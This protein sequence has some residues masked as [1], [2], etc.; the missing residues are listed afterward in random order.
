M[1][2]RENFVRKFFMNKQ[3][4]FSIQKN[5]CDDTFDCIEKHN[6]M[7]LLKDFDT[8]LSKIQRVNSNRKTTWKVKNSTKKTPSYLFEVEVKK[9]N[10][11]K[12][13]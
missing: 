1:R 2:Q 13:S 3:F 12:Q 4:S 8:A 7:V 11:K 6:N 5:L 9:E 10:K